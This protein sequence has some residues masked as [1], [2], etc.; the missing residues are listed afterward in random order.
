M[1]LWKNYKYKKEK[2]NSTN[3]IILFI[4]IKTS[5]TFEEYLWRR[6]PHQQTA[7]Y[8]VLVCFQEFLIFI[9]LL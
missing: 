3:I 7:S 2:E 6:H 5:C 1:L 8:C 4:F 9:W